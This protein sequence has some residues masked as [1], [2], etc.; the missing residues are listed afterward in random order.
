MR[1][2]RGKYFNSSTWTWDDFPIG[3]FHCWG[4]EYKSCLDKMV[5]F[6]V[7]IV[8]LKDG[9]VVTVLPNNLIFLDGVW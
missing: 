2:C 9:T 5:D 3:K 4:S 1:R 8:E 7:G 6:T